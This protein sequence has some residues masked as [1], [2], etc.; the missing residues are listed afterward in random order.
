M[1]YVWNSN[2][3]LPPWQGG[4]L[5]NWTNVPL[6]KSVRRK[7]ITNA[8]C[9]NSQSCMI[10]TDFQITN[11]PDMR[12][13]DSCLITVFHK[14]PSASTASRQELFQST[15]SRG[16]R[17]FFHQYNWLVAAEGFEPTIFWLL[18]KRDR[19]LLQTAIFLWWRK[20]SNLPKTEASR[21][22]VCPIWPLWNFTVYMHCIQDLHLENPMLNICNYSTSSWT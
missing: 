20:D 19:P 4:A 2:P 8:V 18:A 6:K 16:V 5:T 13:T 21:F 14:T 7:F 22:T 1:R 3:R 17:P 15:H 12:I 9:Q 11:L 10:I